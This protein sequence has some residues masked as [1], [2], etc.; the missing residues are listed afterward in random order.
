MTI[1]SCEMRLTT[2]ADFYFPIAGE[3]FSCESGNIRSLT[4]PLGI[5][6]GVFFGS[7]PDIRHPSLGW[8]IFRRFLAESWFSEYA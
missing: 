7:S 4:C 2:Y 8:W 5:V 6:D 3:S 1:T